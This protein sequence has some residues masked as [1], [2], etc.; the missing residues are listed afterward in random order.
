MT[1]FTRTGRPYL[2]PILAAGAVLLAGCGDSATGPAGQGR[3]TVQMSRSGA[4]SAALA[5]LSD[6]ARTDGLAANRTAGVTA[7]AVPLDA[8]ASI[9]VTL[10]GVQALRA[11]DTASANGDD[12][13]W[14][15]LS[16]EQSEVDLM[17]LP[18]GDGLTVASGDVEAGQYTAVR[19][20]F[21]DATITFN[22]EVSFAGGEAERTFAPDTAHPLRIPSGEQTGIKIP[23]A[24][25]NVDGGETE[26]VTVEFDADA[27]V[28]NVQVSAAG[29]IMNPVLA[30]SGGGP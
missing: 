24:S 30:G 3:A 10:D 26:S 8:V 18:E 4:G 17:A 11:G 12:G 23:G 16:V 19:L 20:F 21:S 13:G 14:V 25:F 6:R 5:A 28:Q 29:I 27:S 15:S 1:A 7:A 22:R 9:T 2:A